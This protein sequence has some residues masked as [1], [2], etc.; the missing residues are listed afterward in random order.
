MDVL[1][2]RCRDQRAIEGWERQSTTNRKFE[3]YGIIEGQPMLSCQCEGG[4]VV[5]K[6]INFHRERAKFVP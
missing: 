5:A 3:V 1:S 2:L 6:L 4:A